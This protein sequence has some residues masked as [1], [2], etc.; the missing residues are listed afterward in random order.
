MLPK[1]GAIWPT[2]SSRVPW[3]RYNPWRKYSC[4]VLQTKGSERYKSVL[5][6]SRLWRDKVHRRR[7]LSRRPPNPIPDAGPWQI[8]VNNHNEK[9]KC[10]RESEDD[11]RKPKGCPKS[12]GLCLDFV[13]WWRQFIQLNKIFYQV[14]RP[15]TSYSGLLFPIDIRRPY[16]C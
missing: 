16:K 2:V 7:G 3:N 11:R 5:K 9:L 13:W 6:R 15:G 8:K 10:R 4:V 1:L 12:P 14:S